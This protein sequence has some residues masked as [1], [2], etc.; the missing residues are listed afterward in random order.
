MKIKLK[1]IKQIVEGVVKEA[2]SEEDP[3][4]GRYKSS[5]T[6]TFETVDIEKATRK[7]A[8]AMGELTAALK[9]A[10]SAGGAVKVME[11]SKQMEE[12]NRQLE[13]EIESIIRSYDADARPMKEQE[14]QMV[15]PD[16]VAPAPAGGDSKL[17]A[18]VDIMLKKLPTINTLPEYEQLLAAVL[19]HN[20]PGGENIK[21]KALKDVLLKQFKL[22]ATVVDK[23]LGA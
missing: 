19:T 7:H 18:D 20:I 22:P 17:K 15:D 9:D 12:L 3:R 6:K 21:R 23:I 1:D 5:M 2:L 11:I 4:F 10:L 16:Q 14:E 8:Q 13:Q